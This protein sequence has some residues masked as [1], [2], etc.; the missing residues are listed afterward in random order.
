MRSCDLTEL[1]RSEG[2]LDMLELI[3]VK[4]NVAAE[5][6]YVVWFVCLKY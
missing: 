1:I 5:V 3:D 4:A 6:E 2:G